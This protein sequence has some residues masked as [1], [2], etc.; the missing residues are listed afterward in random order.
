[1]RIVNPIVFHCLLSCVERKGKNNEGGHFRP[2]ARNAQ[3]K[4]LSATKGILYGT[5]CTRMASIAG[6]EMRIRV[7]TESPLRYA[8]AC[9]LHDHHWKNFSFHYARLKSAEILN[10]LGGRKL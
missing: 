8:T 10:F 1:M 4:W 9:P 3:R 6:I 5:L 7:I 2:S